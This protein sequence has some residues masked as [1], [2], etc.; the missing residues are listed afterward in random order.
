MSAAG[1]SPIARPAPMD[2]DEFL[3]V[4]R[5]ERVRDA[6]VAAIDAKLG[7]KSHPLP[8]PHGRF[9]PA[10]HRLLTDIEQ[11]I[12]RLATPAAGSNGD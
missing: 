4:G 5:M 11:Q 8:R 12:R 3:L 2:P 1:E 6:L 9:L 10:A 7:A